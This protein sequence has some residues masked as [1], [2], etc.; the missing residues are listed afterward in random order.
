MMRTICGI[1]IGSHG[2]HHFVQVEDGSPWACLHS[3]YHY[4]GVVHVFGGLSLNISF[5]NNKTC[6]ICHESYTVQFIF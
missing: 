2:R 4:L 1:K 3:L 6:I 5:T